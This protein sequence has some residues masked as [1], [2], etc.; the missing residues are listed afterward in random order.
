MIAS[1]LSKNS[2]CRYV[3]SGQTSKTYLHRAIVDMRFIAKGNESA[4]G[5]LFY[6]KRN[7]FCHGQNSNRASGKKYRKELLHKKWRYKTGGP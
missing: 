1:G 7:P 3:C 6:H 4:N 2:K 5:D